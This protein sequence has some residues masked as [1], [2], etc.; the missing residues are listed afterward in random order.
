MSDN[1]T[2]DVEEAEIS[3]IVVLATRWKRAMAKFEGRGIH[4][5]LAAPEWKM[6][7][8]QIERMVDVTPKNELK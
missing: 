5:Y 3:R 2:V 8:D 1:I 6:S 7:L 4:A